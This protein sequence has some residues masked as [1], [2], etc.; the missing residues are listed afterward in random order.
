MINASP[1]E[2]TVNTLF[3]IALHQAYTIQQTEAPYIPST[4]YFKLRNQG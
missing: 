4:T 3:H 1:L 2:N